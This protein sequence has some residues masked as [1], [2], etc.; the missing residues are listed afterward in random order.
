MSPTLPF[1]PREPD[2]TEQSGGVSDH[3]LLQAMLAGDAAA[4]RRIMGRYDRLIRF[5]VFRLSK[6]QCQRDPQWLDGI[7]SEAWTGFVRSIER[8]PDDLPATISTYLIQIAR[9]RTISKLRKRKEEAASLDEQRQTGSEPVDA[10]DDSHANLA[11]LE[12]LQ[13]LRECV[14]RLPAEERLLYGELEQIT[15]RK[16]RQTAESLGIAESTLRSRWKK[17]TEAL[18]ACLKA[19]ETR[20]LFAP[21]AGDRDS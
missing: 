5:T 16:W 17:V 11:R 10:D 15:A 3:F 1:E 13:A 4:L 9:N 18:S 19:K 14:A 2:P 20:N 12:E 21:D 7:A 6:S 8:R